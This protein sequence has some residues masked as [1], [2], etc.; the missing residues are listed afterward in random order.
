MSSAGGVEIH[1]IGTEYTWDDAMNDMYSALSGIPYKYEKNTD[2]DAFPLK[3][4]RR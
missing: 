3:A 1:Q 4:V 2:E